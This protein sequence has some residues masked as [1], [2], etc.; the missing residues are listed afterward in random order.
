M[1]S[2]EEALRVGSVGSFPWQLLSPRGLLLCTSPPDTPRDHLVP[3]LSKPRPALCSLPEGST[4]LVWIIPATGSS[5]PHQAACFKVRTFFCIESKSAH[6]QVPPFGFDSLKQ[7][8][9]SQ[10]FL[11]VIKMV[12][13]ILKLCV[14]VWT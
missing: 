8:R 13:F 5:L 12:F 11:T 2:R 9:A 10:L 3:P 7:H 6:F 1:V 14:K 4:S